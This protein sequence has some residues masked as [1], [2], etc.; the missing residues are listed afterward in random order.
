MKLESVTDWRAFWH[1]LPL[2]C[3]SPVPGLRVY[4][5]KRGYRYAMD[6]FLLAGFA[7]EGGAFSRFVEVGSGCGVLSLVLAGGGRQGLG[8]D[9]EPAWIAL[10][11]RSATESALS[12][13]VRFLHGDVRSFSEDPA[14]VGVE[15]VLCNPPYFRTQSGALPADRLAA[16]AR[17]DLHGSLGEIVASAARLGGRVCLVLPLERVREAMR[18]LDSAGRPLRRRIDLNPRLSLLEGVVDWVGPVQREELSMRVEGQHNPRII[19]WYA[20]LGASLQAAGSGIAAHRAE[21]GTPQ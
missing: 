13:R 15:V 3:E 5:P 10:S 16:S 12:D 18:A 7:L 14:L 2:S 1:D 19:A 21:T 20:A 4:Q 8:I 6:P 11:E 17:F 9:V